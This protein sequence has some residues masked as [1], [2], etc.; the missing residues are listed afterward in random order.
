MSSSLWLYTGSRSEQGRRINSLRR[1]SVSYTWRSFR[2]VFYSTSS[3]AHFL[4]VHSACAG[5]VFRAHGV[6]FALHFTIKSLNRAEN[7]RR[8]RNRSKVLGFGASEPVLE[9]SGAVFVPLKKAPR[10]YES[11]WQFTTGLMQGGV[12]G[13]PESLL[14]RRT[15]IL[16]Y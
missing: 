4:A 15:K 8:K 11:V 12:W 7:R 10:T 13:P 2:T 1:R 16:R 3:L 6:H 14:R 5:A 9:R